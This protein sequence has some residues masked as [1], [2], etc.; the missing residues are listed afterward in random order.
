MLEPVFVRGSS[1]VEKSQLAAKYIHNTILQLIGEKR[2]K[3]CA[4]VA[5]L[6]CDLYIKKTRARLQGACYSSTLLLMGI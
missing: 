6:F 1:D 4:S 3:S 5:D 2:Q